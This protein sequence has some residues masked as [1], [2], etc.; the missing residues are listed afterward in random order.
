MASAN[1]S[2]G[3]FPMTPATT[4]FTSNAI[5]RGHAQS[6]AVQSSPTRR[7]PNLTIKASHEMQRGASCQDNFAAMRQHARSPDIPSP[8]NTAPLEHR[9]SVD[10]AAFPQP[11]LFNMATLKMDIP[12]WDDGYNAAN[13][14]PMSNAVSSAMSSFQS[15]PEMPHMALFEHQD[16]G[17]DGNLKTSGSLILPASQSAMNLGSYSSSAKQES[18]ASSQ[19]RSEI[20]DP[21][22]CIEETGVTCDEIA[23]F[24]SFPD[25]DNK[26]TCLFTECGK[27]FGRK[28]N[29]KAHVQTHLDDR[30]FRCNDCT[31]RFVRQHDLKRHAN[32][33]SGV[34][35]YSCPC[36]KGFAR[37]DALTRHRQRGMCIGAFEGTPKKIAKRGRPK[38]SRP[39]VEGR[40]EKSAATRQR[41]LEKLAQRSPSKYASSLSGSSIYSHPSPEQF[42]SALEQVATPP[43]HVST[44]PELGDP[45]SS[46]AASNF[47]D[48]DD[49]AEAPVPLQS[50]SD[51][52]GAD[53]DLS[54]ALTKDNNARDIDE[55]LFE[56]YFG[57]AIGH[58]TAPHDL[59]DNPFISDNPWASESW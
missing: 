54:V 10:M 16:G 47:F 13:Y 27:K 5:L 40:L 24:I 55:I 12:L 58:V 39:E 57:K 49:S 15:S 53:I 38:K 30:Q 45:S 56:Q 26:W 8:P 7:D 29:I 42:H 36:G 50:R 59:G 25:A 43:E 34:R 3:Y 20:E 21:N 4:P 19:S 22:E 33:H 48:F 44:P 28:E 46:P 51:I 1:I 37:H 18:H 23:A 2:E 32:I 14:S 17:A 9:K 11:N 31:K 6:R 52:F 35:S 41:A